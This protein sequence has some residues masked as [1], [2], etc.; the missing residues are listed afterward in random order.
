MRKGMFALAAVGLLAVGS[1]AACGGDDD[2]GSGST[3]GASA[4]PGKVGVI[5]PD[6]ASSQRWSTADNKYLKEAFDAAGVQADI[7]NAQGDKSQFQTIADGMISSGVKVLMIVNLDSGTG[8]AVLDKAKAAGIATIDYDRLTLNGGASYH[9]SFDNRAV[10]VQ[11]GLGL[12]R[13]LDA[14]VPRKAKPI[15]AA[16]N[17]PP[18]DS[19]A[20]LYR[21]G[22]NSVLEDRYF[23]GAYTKGPDQDVTDWD[24]DL[25][26]AI[27]DQMMSQTQNRIDGV[28]AADDGFAGAVVKQLAKRDLNGKIPVAGQD[29]D[30]AAL[31][32]ILTGDQCMTVLKDTRK[33]AA[34]AA[35]LAVSM[36]KGQPRF[37]PTSVKDTESGLDV[38]AILMKPQSIFKENG[39]GVVAAGFVSRAALCKGR[40]APLCR[41]QGI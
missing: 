28:V 18:S 30:V 31:Q 26:G 27:F 34:T 23:S 25:A 16:L 39:K 14:Q 12:A 19:S 21:N 1:V 37:A 3:G 36:A 24:D 10:G 15:I 8:K 7:Q 20:T 41:E 9:V 13:C 32:R 35:E 4:A 2:T 6:T 38:K 29:A 5:L 40:I 33:E 22:Y 11:Q 17:G